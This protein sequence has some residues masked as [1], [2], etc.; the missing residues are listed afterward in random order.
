MTKMQP[1]NIFISYRRGDSGDGA[2][3]LSYLLKEQLGNSSKIFID[4]DDIPIG[5]NF[6]EHLTAEVARCDVLLAVIGPQ[7]LDLEG[8]KYRRS[9]DD[10]EDY[11]RIEIAA[12]LQRKIAVVPILLNGATIPRADQ[13]PSDLRELSFRNGRQIRHASF[14]SDVARLAHELKQIP[15]KGREPPPDVEPPPKAKVEP[16]PKADV[17]ALPKPTFEWMTGKINDPFQWLITIAMVVGA[18]WL[19][20]FRG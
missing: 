12:A 10:P 20:F 9:V 6:V 4:V 19:V 2:V 5:I 16:P 8:A 1:R 7:W 3:L 17:E 15:T 18:L 14:P 13:L 11:V